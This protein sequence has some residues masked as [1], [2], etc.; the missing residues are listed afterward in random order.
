MMKPEV[1]C[2]VN[3]SSTQMFVHESVCV[4]VCVLGKQALILGFNLFTNN[5]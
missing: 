3:C 5:L 4:C 1:V 2:S